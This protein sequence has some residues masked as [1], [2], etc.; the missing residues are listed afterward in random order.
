MF[1]RIARSWSLVKASASVLRSDSE[2]LVFPL[3]SSVSALLVLVSFVAPMLLLEGI[4]PRS[5]RGDEVSPLLLLWLFAFYLC[6]YFVIFF[7]NSALVGAALI[8]LE[9]G[10]PTLADGL[11]IAVSRIGAIFGYA[12]IAATVG[13]LL[14]MLEERA[15]WLGRWVVGALGVAWTVASFLVVPILVQRQIGPWAAVQESARMLRKSWGE[16]IIGAGGIGL[17][18]GLIIALVS[19]LGI[20]AGVAALVAGMIGFGLTLLVLTVLAVLLLGLVQ[21][22]LAAIYSAA[23]YRYASGESAQGFDAGMLQSAFRAK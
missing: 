7:F 14:R 10:D 11:R 19:V 20:G 15:G 1:E 23:L 9:G 18:G 17:A 3:L 8:R 22:A 6:N 12:L 13:L 21:A 4:D 2:L 5:L 16:N